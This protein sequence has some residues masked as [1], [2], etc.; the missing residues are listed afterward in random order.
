MTSS[1]SATAFAFG[2]H[3]YNPPSSLISE[4]DDNDIEKDF[5]PAQKFL[6][7]DTAKALP[8]AAREKVAVA[9]KVRFSEYLNKLF[10]KVNAVFEN[11]D[12]KPPFDDAE[13]L[14]RPEMTTIPYTQVMFKTLKEEKLPN[15]LK[16]FSGSSSGRS[17]EL[18]IRAT[19]KK[20]C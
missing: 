7:G 14:S 12:Q 18:K 9:G 11:K 4:D 17:N 20:E 8:L 13:P 1:I 6:L 5:T 3:L 15:Q 16:F 19:E 10:P 2:L